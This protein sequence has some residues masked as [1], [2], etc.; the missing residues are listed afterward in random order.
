MKFSKQRLKE[1][2]REEL[3]REGRKI[4]RNE[5]LPN[6]ITDKF[7]RVKDEPDPGA[8]EDFKKQHSTSMGDGDSG[9]I[10]EPD[11]YDWDDDTNDKPGYQ[12]DEKDKKKKGYEPVTEGRFKL[13]GASEMQWGGNKI[14]IM[15]GKGKIA[16]DK[17][18]LLNM[19]RGIKMHRLAN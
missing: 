9:T 14:V 13:S 1:I 10:S 17:K 5:T 18:E 7:K 12:G 16:L 8:G 19:L 15:T 11:T 2:I 4:T 6:K 3:F